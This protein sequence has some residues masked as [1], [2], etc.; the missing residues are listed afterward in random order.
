MPDEYFYDLKTAYEYG[1]A[2]NQPF[3]IGKRFVVD[4]KISGKQED[5]DRHGPEIACLNFDRNG[6]AGYFYSVEVPYNDEDN[7][8]LNSFAH[9]CFYDFFEVPNPF[10]RDDIVKCIGTDGYGIVD[11]SQEMRKESIAKF[12]NSEW[13]QKYWDFS[14]IQIRVEFLREDRTFD[15]DHVNTIDLERY[16]PEEDWSIGIPMDKLLLCASEV[17]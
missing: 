17:L 13:H 14:N 8:I 12:K 5:H 15:Y 11:T 1:R 7:E 10:E 16:Y 4:R 6:E 3:Q 2:E 9:D